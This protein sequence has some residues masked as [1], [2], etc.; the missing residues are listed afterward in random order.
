MFLLHKHD[1]LEHLETYLERVLF[2]IVL[3]FLSDGKYSRSAKK[4][5]EHYLKVLFL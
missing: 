5:I 1:D 2:L 4:R 3:E